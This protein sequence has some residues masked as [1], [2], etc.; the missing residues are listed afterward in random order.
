[1]GVSVLWADD[2]CEELLAT[3]GK[4]LQRK[5]LDLKKAT[6]YEDAAAKLGNGGIESALLDI[7]LPHKTGVTGAM[8]PD[9]GLALADRIAAAG[10]LY[11]A[12]LTVTR[13][14]DVLEKY[15]EMGKRHPA[16]RFN[17]FDKTKLLERGS[18]DKVADFLKSPARTA[19]K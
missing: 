7:I 13:Q 12:F 3:F 11:V 19:T 4:I 18:I 9:L 5:G 2:D 8:A 16:V 14:D 17:Y 15:I 1:M 10:V 6:N